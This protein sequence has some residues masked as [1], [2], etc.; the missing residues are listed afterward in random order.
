MS[1]HFCYD[2]I[3]VRLCVP[4]SHVDKI[5]IHSNITKL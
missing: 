5:E 4:S 1:I 2:F 3:A